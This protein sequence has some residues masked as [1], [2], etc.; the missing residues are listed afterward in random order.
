MAQDTLW[1]VA[2][3]LLWAFNMGRTVDESGEEVAVAGEYT[4]GVVWCVAAAHS[5]GSW[6]A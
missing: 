6:W 4:F 3:Q 2:A 5:T 1:I